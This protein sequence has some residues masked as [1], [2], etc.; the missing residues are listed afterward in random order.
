MFDAIANISTFSILVPLAFVVFVKGRFVG[1]LAL[2]FFV[3][4]SAVFEAFFYLTSFYKFRNLP[5]YHLY[6]LFEFVS[7]SC[8]AVIIIEQE[9]S[10]WMKVLIIATS[11]YLIVNPFVWENLNYYNS[12]SRS[13]ASIVLLLMFLL[14]FF[15]VYKEEAVVHLERQPSFWLVSGIMIYL[16]MGLFTHLL[17]DSV[18]INLDGTDTF[19]TSYAFVQLSNIVKNIAITFGIWKGKT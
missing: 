14:Y 2:S 19:L 18:L 8:L 15:K 17:A 9:K 12:I 10:L 1:R 5:Y 6:T 11:M 16:A 4:G 7:L 3:I 13:V